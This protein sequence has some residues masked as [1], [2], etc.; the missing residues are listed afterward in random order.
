MTTTLSEKAGQISSDLVGDPQLL[1]KVLD[2]LIEK[3][4]QSKLP[5]QVVKIA[6]E[7]QKDTG[8]NEEAALKMAWDAYAKFINPGAAEAAGV[9]TAEPKAAKPGAMKTAAARDLAEGL[10]GVFGK[11]N[12]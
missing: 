5:E 9:K 4:S 6:A 10:A 1:S 11:G 12:E 7:I 2:G 8:V 3:T